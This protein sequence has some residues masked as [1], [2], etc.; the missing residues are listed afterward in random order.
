MSPV[1]V[2]TVVIVGATGI[3]GQILLTR[4][5]LVCFGGNELTLG[6]IVGS[7]LLLEA[8]GSRSAA[9]VRSS[10]SFRWFVGAALLSA[11]A[12]PAMIFL[13]RLARPVLGIL[14]GE[15]VPP[16]TMILISTALL[17]PVSILHGASFTLGTGL[18][19]DPGFIRPSQTDSAGWLRRIYL[20]ESVGSVVGGMLISLFLLG[21]VS[22]I[23][24]GLGCWTA[25]LVA[26][27]LLLLATRRSS[28]PAGSRVGY[29]CLFSGLLAISI[30]GL[31]SG[32][33]S[34][35]EMVSLRLR[36]PES[37]VLRHTDSH[38]GTITVLELAGQVSI[39]LD[40]TPSVTVPVPDYASVE[41]IIHL[42]M[43]A[44][45]PRARRQ[46]LFIGNGL[47][48]PLAELMKYPGVQ[49]DYCELNPEIPALFRQLVPEATELES[50]RITI[51]AV[52][53]RQYLQRM[54]P[55]VYDVIIVAL[56]GPTTL[57]ANRYFTAEFFR[58]VRSRLQPEGILATA[59]PGSSSYLDDGLAA[60][61][62]LQ[63][64]TLSSVFAH[65]RIFPGDLNIYISSDSPLVGLKT[66]SARLDSYQLVTRVV[67]P[68][69]LARR[70]DALQY[71]NFIRRIETARLPS[72]VH[73]SDMQP[74]GVAV[75]LSSWT[76]AANPKLGRVML[77][78][79]TGSR[80]LV[81]VIFLLGIM[82]AAI[83]FLHNRYQAR[84]RG[85]SGQDQRFA[86]NFVIFST[87]AA[88]AAANL[89]ILLAVQLIAGTL[90]FYLALVTAGFMTGT[91]GGALWSS[92]L[93]AR[94]LYLLEIGIGLIGIVVAG[95]ILPGAGPVGLRL[96]LLI[97]LSVMLGT[98]LGAEFPLVSRGYL[99]LTG[100]G[101]PRVAGPLYALDLVGGFL[102]AVATPVWF[103]PVIGMLPAAIGILVMKVMSILLLRLSSAAAGNLRSPV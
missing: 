93:S 32:L 102:G 16:G 15:I 90:Y 73:N 98:M 38:Y 45:L 35:L 101:A 48:G 1:L 55:G 13:A 76:A 27:E 17:A 63:R 44:S 18:S 20:W 95:L 64:S 75:A 86:L 36:Y 67:T 70:F 103:V 100:T 43:L 89:L 71:D 74:F 53:A 60:L 42:P 3:A 23:A 82:L 59:L 58:L 72:G 40:G 65:T 84:I 99:A 25:N 21:R 56:T 97:V 91:A 7:W 9:R 11:G 81:V 10:V 92:R 77:R 29:C 31:V 47:G 30:A 61:N 85:A 83:L 24:L 80:Q 5:L 49:V 2:I 69:H 37:R 94:Q 26:L 4:E 88:A 62:H 79:W 54:P 28:A 96:G 6:I 39:L 68:E 41:D 78:F 19:A 33:P 52:D 50:S 34:R 46:V 14:P 57:Q 22:A 12:V 51:R 87:G 66:M 8:I